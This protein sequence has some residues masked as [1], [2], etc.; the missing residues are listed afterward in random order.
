LP[1]IDSVTPRA[2]PGLRL[3]GD[4]QG[5]FPDSFGGKR[6]SFPLV[7]DGSD[8]IIPTF[9]SGKSEVTT[10]FKFVVNHLNNAFP[11]RKVAF[12]RSDLGGEFV[13]N[14]LSQFLMEHGIKNETS[15]AKSH[16]SNWTH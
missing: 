8:F 2:E 7:D 4:L 9:L 1:Y 15:F 13:S 6:Y 10:V 14:E 5:K 16:Q 12:F 11:N 3:F